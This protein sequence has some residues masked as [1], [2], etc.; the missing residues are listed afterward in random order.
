MR[1]FAENKRGMSTVVGAVFGVITILMGFSFILWEVTQYD[2]HAQ[3]INERNR[4]DLDRKN[5][6]MEIVDA[7]I[8][9]EEL[10]FSVIN[11]GPVTS[12]IV[13]LW[14]TEYGATPRH[15]GPIS[16]NTYVNP[17][18][19]ITFAETPFGGLNP[20]LNY[21]IKV[22]TERGNVVMKLLEPVVEAGT[23]GEFT[24]GPFNLI[25]SNQSFQFTSSSFPTTPKVAFQID[26]DNASILFWIQIQN[27]AGR[28]I[29]I[30]KQSFFLVEVRHLDGPG[31]PGSTEYERYFHITNS[32]STSSG[33][34]AYNPDYNQVISSGE[35]ATLKF[36]AKT[37]G[38]TSFLNPEGEYQ[39][40]QGDDD[41]GNSY[42]NLLW[43]FLVIFWR[44][45]GD[46]DTFGQ[47]IA[48]AAIR[49]L[50]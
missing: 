20:E 2:A 38:G 30:S 15:T 21:L 7:S 11:K 24:A 6:I 49:T 29:Q 31:D 10:R 13:D 40:L 48:Y 47:T 3:V 25:F 26:N 43:T 9:D 19:T 44:Y 17:G 28:P 36:G 34:V 22:V 41:N 8:V 5:E 42:E 1:H 46:L 50:P 32:T 4:L 18:S 37:V 39:P 27:Q 14:F 33:L 12:H 23:G 16:K 45:E 35:T